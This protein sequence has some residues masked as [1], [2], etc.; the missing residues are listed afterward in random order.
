MKSFDLRFRNRKSL[1]EIPDTTGVFLFSDGKEILYTA[2]TANL[3]QT[4]AR[5]LYPEEEDAK[6]NSLMQAS[7]RLEWEEKESLLEALLWQKRVFEH[8]LP[9]FQSRIRPYDDYCYLAINLE[10]HPFLSIQEQVQHADCYI[11]PFRSRFYLFDVMDIVS[12]MLHLPSCSV[13]EFPCERSN[14]GLCPAYCLQEDQTKLKHLLIQTYLMPTP[15][16]IMALQKEYEKLFNELEFE[17]S[18][19]IE[20]KMLQLRKYYDYLKFFYTAKRLE[21]TF[22]EGK[23][24][25]T[26]KNGLLTSYQDN[27]GTVE[28]FAVEAAIAYRDSEYLAINKEQID[29][30][31]ILYQHA[32]DANPE[33]VENIYRQAIIQGVEILHQSTGV[34][35][36]QA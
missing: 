23:G 13:D 9:S 33:E 29:E 18:E 6:L 30:M 19:R 4:I 12:E 21:I 24:S 22:A 15:F 14:D 17:A 36:E 5:Y 34:K 32:K 1:A 35:K 16:L 10:H 27:S 2:K 7:V 20:W 26:V 8:G 11:G 25:Y 31:W 28:S 3:K